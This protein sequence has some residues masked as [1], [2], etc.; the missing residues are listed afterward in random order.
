MRTYSASSV[1]EFIR[2]VSDE[3][4]TI[5]GYRGV[6]NIAY[7]L[8]PSIGRVPKES[9]GAALLFE[10][11]M[12]EEF[13]RELPSF[14]QNKSGTECAIIAQHHGLPTRL[15][16]WTSNPLVALYF[17]TYTNPDHDGCV[18]CLSPLIKKIKE[19]DIDYG[20]LLLMTEKSGIFAPS[21]VKL[22][23]D[24]SE[25]YANIMQKRFNFAYA[26]LKP[27]AITPRV[28]RQHSFFTIHPN[29]FLSI[30]DIYVKITIPKQSKKDLQNMLS[31][32]GVNAYSLFPDLG[33]LASAIKRNYFSSLS[34]IAQAQ[35]LSDI[36]QNAS[37]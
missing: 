11:S 21:K 10:E 34:A 5:G 6:S 8:I 20:E 12:F 30:T 25:N 32:L 33:G 2:V 24:I 27:S 13:K 19:Q 35:I 14:E 23:P 36:S 15:L 9:R 26:I 31:V 22:I 37:K 16:D 7:E 17:A 1:E 29:P 3:F 4:Y 28:S 18:Y